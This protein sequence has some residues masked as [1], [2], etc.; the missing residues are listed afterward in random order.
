[1][2]LRQYRKKKEK[3]LFILNLE[4]LDKP[5]ARLEMGDYVRKSLLTFAHKTDLFASSPR[6]VTKLR[7]EHSW[8]ADEDTRGKTKRNFVNRYLPRTILEKSTRLL[9]CSAT[10][11]CVISVDT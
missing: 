3:T 5:D 11:I 9:F 10:D 2:R 1:V 7:R 6:N 8:K 4:K